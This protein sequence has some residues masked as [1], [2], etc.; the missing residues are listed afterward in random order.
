MAEHIL[1]RTLTIDLP[2]EDVFEFFADAGNLERIT[3][4][5]LNFHILTPQPIDIKQGTLIDYKLKMRGIPIK[6]RTEISVWEPPYRFVDQQLRGAYRQWIHTH[7]FTELSRT[8]T[9]ME[10]EVRYRLPI[11]PLGDIAHFFVKSEL[12]YIFDYRQKVVAEMLGD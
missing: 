2:R 4:P 9:L 1:T 8:Q 6:W 12:D 7:T 5:E 10:D 11:E 3:P